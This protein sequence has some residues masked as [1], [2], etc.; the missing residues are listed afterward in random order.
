MDDFESF[1]VGSYRRLFH[2]LLLVTA[3][4]A[5]TE[6]VLQDAYTRA[7]VRWRRVR[8]LDN[9]E[10]WVRRVAINRSLDLHRRHSRQRR[11]YARLAPAVEHQDDLSL[12]VLDAL[13]Q[14]LP[15]LRQVVV[16]HHLL[17]ETVESIAAIVGRPTGT[18]K[19][20]LVRG[21][22]ALHAALSPAAEELS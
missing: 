12:E 3:D 1:Y 4:Q 5:D 10:A 14:L 2:D 6:D 22:A 17:G 20:Q 18:V 19:G 15:E 11:A 16:L 7:A 8:S 9:P 21:R 13:R